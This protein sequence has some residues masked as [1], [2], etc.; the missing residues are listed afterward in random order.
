MTLPLCPI[1]CA[2]SEM[3]PDAS[4][5]PGSARTWLNSEVEKDGG[6]E[7][8]SPCSSPPIALLPVI[9]TSVFLYTRVNTV[10]K[11]DLIVSVRMYVP[12]TIATPMTIAIAV[13]EARTLRPSRPFS[14]TRITATAPALVERAHHLEHACRGGVAQLVDDQ[15]VGQEQDPVRDRCAARVVRHDH[16]RLPV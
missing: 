16:D 15:S 13:S 6:S 10:E 4:A 12:L 14:A 9:T 1:S 2:R 11:A 3:P 7:R 8:S 5:T